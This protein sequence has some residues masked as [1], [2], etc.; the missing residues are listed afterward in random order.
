MSFFVNICPQLLANNID[1]YKIEIRELIYLDPDKALSEIR[2]SNTENTDDYLL[3]LEAMCLSFLC[4][5]EEAN[6]VFESLLNKVQDENLKMRTFIDYATHLGALGY[7]KKYKKMIHAIDSSDI[8]TTALYYPNYLIAK[9]R[10]IT[11]FDTEYKILSNIANNYTAREYVEKRIYALVRLAN[12]QRIKQKDTEA[13]IRTLGKADSISRVFN[14]QKGIASTKHYLSIFHRKLGAN[15]LSFKY[16]QE[17]LD[18]YRAINDKKGIINC[19][20]VLG[21][22]AVANRDTLQATEYNIKA[23]KLAKNA[24]LLRQQTHLLINNAGNIGGLNK[25]KEDLNRALNLAVEME[26]KDLEAFASYNLGAKYQEEE[27]YFTADKYYQRAYNS[28]L[29]AE[30]HANIAWV[31]PR[32]VDLYV[33][34]QKSKPADYQLKYNDEQLEEMLLNSLKASKETKDYLNQKNTYETLIKFYELRGRISQTNILRKEYIEIQKK[35][36]E[37]DQLE[38]A[39]RFAAEFETAEKEIEILQLESEKEVAEVKS[40]QFKFLAFGGMGFIAM[41]SFFGYNYIQYQ[42]R[43]KQ[44]IQKEKFRSKLSSDLH[45]DVGTILTGLAMQS[46]LLSDFVDDSNKALVENLAEMSRD[47]MSRMRD[48]VWAIDSRKDKLIDL[49]DRILD[50][51]EESFSQS[52]VQFIFNDENLNIEK[53]IDP[54]IRQNMYLIFKEAISNILKYSNGDRVEAELKTS[55]KVLQLSVRDNGVF[56]VS[57]IK[58]SGTGL[59]NMKMRAEKMGGQFELD[60]TDGFKISVTALLK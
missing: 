16:A 42:N 54:E 46:E 22:T 6:K 4:E 28:F 26:A 56:E 49:K 18:I 41:I 48:T 3:Y 53:N 23:L 35:I 12:L 21:A 32:I 34:W 31:L 36:F 39:E 17:S 27:N 10:L 1:P 43:K 20:V 55:N 7:T 14:F 2:E 19:Y 44:E 57:K 59:S 13:G 33:L 51:G 15:D 58:K 11:S 45:D 30:Q 24:G 50:Y 40:K 8:D 47:A 37:K 60:T 38:A 5:N 9:A 29:E 52:A 25:A